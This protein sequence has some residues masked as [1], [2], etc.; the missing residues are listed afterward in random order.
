LI[1]TWLIYAYA[2]VWM[3]RLGSF[4]SAAAFVSMGQVLQLGR[5]GESEAVFTLFTAASLLVWHWGYMR[6]WPMALVWSLGYTLAALAALTKGPQAP[7][8]FVSTC[9]AYLLLRR[10]WRWLLARGHLTG[11]AC[12]ALTVSAWLVPFAIASG[13]RAVDDIWTGLAE[14]RFRF[15]GL[16]RHLATYPFETFGCLL[17]WS[18]ILCLL[19][20]PSVRKW[21]LANRPQFQFLVAALVVTYPTVWFATG[22]MGRY[23]MPLYP[24]L[25]V[26]I[27]LVIESCTHGDAGAFDRNSWRLYLRAVGGVILAAGF[28]VVAISYVPLTQFD[29]ARQ[30]L[31]FQAVWI[32]AA[33]LAAS[34]LIWASFGEHA[35]RPQIAVLTVAAFAGLAYA[36]AIVNS[37]VH[38][39]NDLTPAIVHLKEQ[40]GDPGQIVSL[41]RVYHRFAYEY[42]TPIRQIAW[43]TT[44]AEL[45]SQFDYFCFDERPGDPA[46]KQALGR[47]PFEWD[48][49]ARFGCDPV[50]R[51]VPQR[52]VVVGRVRR[53]GIAAQPSVSRPALR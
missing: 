3:S 46:L 24:C 15:H 12:F 38:G 35:P 37:R 6:A 19:I 23:Y 20:K 8:Y 41:D 16:L 26:L 21:L 45:P 50:R 25:A 49:V 27:G 33:V 11:L 52:S 28:V 9:G 48:V 29:D 14:E 4:A 51:D 7:V 1:L 22:A 13:W 34:V 31:A 17:P 44:A 39:S 2:R 18:P 5:T 42:G 32:V 36:G 53:A 43:P 30:P 47:L 10:D 40:L